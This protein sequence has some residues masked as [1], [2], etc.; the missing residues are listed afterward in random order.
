M[1]DIF[2]TLKSKYMNYDIVYDKK[3]NFITIKKDN[4]KIECDD[5]ILY[6]YVKNK[7]IT[8]V[9]L[10]DKETKDIYQTIIYFINNYNKIIRNQIIIDVVSV[11]GTIIIVALIIF[12]IEFIK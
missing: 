3:F 11:I 9:H 8:H 6:L 4:M 1:Y 2:K 12:L 7:D 5:S 10:D